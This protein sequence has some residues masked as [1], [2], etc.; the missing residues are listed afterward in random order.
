MLLPVQPP[1]RLPLE[2]VVFDARLSLL[3]NLF[4]LR[5]EESTRKKQKK[6]FENRLTN[7]ASFY[8][9]KAPI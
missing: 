3:Q 5:G 2:A 9:K 4:D 8:G 1:C 7:D 6:V